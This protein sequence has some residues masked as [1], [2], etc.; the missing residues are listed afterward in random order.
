MNHTSYMSSL[1]YATIGQE[2]EMKANSGLTWSA[3]TRYA[4][5]ATQHNI[6]FTYIERRKHK[7]HSYDILSL[8]LV[9]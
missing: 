6:D 9:Y 1:H 8:F 7:T 2:N 3:A 5:H 4:L